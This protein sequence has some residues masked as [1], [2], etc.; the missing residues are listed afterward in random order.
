MGQL[1]VDPGSLDTAAATLQ[2]AGDDGM[3]TLARAI[4][5]DVRD[6]EG[7]SGD[8]EFSSVLPQLIADVAERT[9]TIANDLSTA[10]ARYRRTEWLIRMALA[11]Q[12]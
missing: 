5:E 4:V 10:A 11:K 12:A 1:T 7:R 6:G 3:T 8:A 9:A 2:G